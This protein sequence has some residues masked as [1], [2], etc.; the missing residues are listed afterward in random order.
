[1]L[2]FT[3]IQKY[4]LRAIL[5]CWEWT[6]CSLKRH[7]VNFF[8]S[9]KTAL[10]CGKSCIVITFVWSLGHCRKEAL[11]CL[12]VF[13]IFSPCTQHTHKMRLVEISF[14][15]RRAYWTY[16]SNYSIKYFLWAANN[17]I[18][19]NFSQCMHVG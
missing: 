5:K 8:Y 6:L 15:Q 17:P 4:V 12:F 13:A 18:L 1:M 16:D 2:A 14:P 10:I 11:P 7:F 3:Q 9:E 19:L